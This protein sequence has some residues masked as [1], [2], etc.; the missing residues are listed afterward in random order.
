VL[1]TFISSSIV[2]TSFDPFQSVNAIAYAVIGGLGY[3]LGP[4]LG[5]NLASGGTGSLFQ[6]LIPG[7][8]PWL[9]LIGGVF[10]VLVLLAN[11]NGLVDAHGA[12]LR[13]AGR[14]ARR[15][16]P[17]RWQAR[18]QGAVPPEPERDSGFV[19]EADAAAVVDE[20]DRIRVRGRILRI[21]DLT[22]RYGGVTAVNGV[23]LEVG[24]GEVVGL[25]GPNGAGKTSLIDAVS[26]FTRPTSGRVI[27]DGDDLLKLRAHGRAL[28]GVVRSWQALELF[29]DVSVRENL[30]AGSDSAGSWA[31]M[32]QWFWPAK[33]GLGLQAQAAVHD[34][35]LGPDLDRLPTDIPYGRRR[36]V[37]IARA[38]AMSPSI[39][40]LDEPAAGL[41]DQEARELGALARRLAGEWGMG[42]LLVEHNIELVMDVC[43]RVVVIDF[44]TVIATGSPAEVR[45]NPAVIA[46]YLGSEDSVHSDDL[47]ARPQ[48]AYQP[49]VR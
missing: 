29:E 32:A 12:Q 22:V 33:S 20:A 5:S 21:E 38:V 39:L 26:G 19:E 15:L 27:L 37:G 23:S 35:Q 40:L 4:V 24:S 7:L 1:L 9:T 2:L 36:L 14:H 48:A 18:A 42:I 34:C 11:H 44:G 45:T 25:I 47:V 16:L 46:A 49:N 3:L 31:R 13:Y 28:G 43:D 30:Q 8:D 17:R 10:L 6:K 41:S